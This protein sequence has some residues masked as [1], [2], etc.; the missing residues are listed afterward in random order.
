MIIARSPSEISRDENT[1]L[2]VGTFDGVHQGHRA[3][4]EELISRAKK[5]SSRT[6]VVTFEP[7]PKEVV[8]KGEVHL[9]AG[10]DERLDLLRKLGVDTVLVLQFTHAFSRLTPREFF[11]NYIIKY[12]GV[13]EVVVGHDHMFGRNREAGILELQQ[14]GKEHG[15]TAVAVNPV[16]VDDQIVSSSFIRETLQ[17]GEVEKASRLLGRRYNLNG[18]VVKGDGRGR[19]IGFPTANI[20]PDT[21]K[22]LVPLE[23]VYCV[24][25]LVDAH[26]HVGM[27]NIGVAPT[28]GPGRTRTVE[29][30]L[31][32]VNETLYGHS[33][34]VRFLRRIREEKKFSSKEQLIEQLQHDRSEC[35]GCSTASQLS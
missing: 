28:F 14:I 6:V 3:I 9:L 33:L 34:E 18:I 15:F 1:I 29:V 25:V 23:G 10:L 16:L 26:K 12:V 24:E 21:P 27:L 11:E 17:K 13:R 2:T 31:F 30:H 20:Q 35:L 5:H 32:D 8:G 19:E 7:H 22:K 4:V